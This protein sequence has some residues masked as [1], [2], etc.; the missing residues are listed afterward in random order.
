[1]CVCCRPF[2]YTLDIEAVSCDEMYVDC[3]DLLTDTASSP[4]EFASLLRQEIHD[5]TGCTASVGIGMFL[6]F[7]P[8]FALCSYSM[9]VFAGQKVLQASDSQKN[10]MQDTCLWA[11]AAFASGSVLSNH[12]VLMPPANVMWPDLFVCPSVRV[13]TLLENLE[14]SGS[15]KVVREKSGKIGKI[16]EKSGKMNYY[17]YSV[18]AIIVQTVI[19]DYN[20]STI[21][22]SR[23]IFW[24]Y[25]SGKNIPHME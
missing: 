10:C 15:W 2:S 8:L 12:V 19:C 4:L 9:H 17:N 21:D 3:I 16:R 25:F 20:N 6:L 11:S 23:L 7:S 13:A 14:K 5:K 18:A 1:M 22:H 24:L